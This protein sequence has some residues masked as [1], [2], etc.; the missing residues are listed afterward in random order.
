MT[1]ERNGAEME[2]M[3]DLPV[4]CSLT[5]NG[6]QER[7]HG[8]FS[9]VRAHAKEV[10][11]LE[12]GYALRFEPKDEALQAVADLITSERKCCPFLMFT[13]KVSQDHGPVWLELTGPDGTKSFLAPM[14]NE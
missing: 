2:A 1:V 12:A 6:L 3:K 11:P 5:A 9:L 10:K 14:L 13:L 8:V 7:R 4:A